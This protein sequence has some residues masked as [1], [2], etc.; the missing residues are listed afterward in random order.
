MD[1]PAINLR[2]I[3]WRAWARKLD[4]LAYWS[5]TFWPYNVRRGEPV[6]DKWPNSPWETMSHPMGNG[7]GHFIYPGPDGHPLSSFRLENLRDAQEDYEYLYTLRALTDKLKDSNEER[8]QDLIDESEKLLDVDNALPDPV[9]PEMLYQLRD[10][11]AY[12][13]E[14]IKVLFK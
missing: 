9:S 8:Y 7:D 14:K 4:G 2:K 1:K 3:H 13:I 12:Q 11:I 10:Q 6:R 5:T